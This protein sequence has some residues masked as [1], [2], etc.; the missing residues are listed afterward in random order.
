[1][2]IPKS[3]DPQRQ[4]ENFSVF[5]FALTEDEMAA[6]CRLARPGGR[7]VTPSWSPRWDE[8]T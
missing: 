2:A 6:I 7:M 1:V 4:R 3:G 8:A 5:D